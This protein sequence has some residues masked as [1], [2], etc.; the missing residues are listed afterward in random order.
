MGFIAES[1]ALA[2][3]VATR[4]IGSEAESVESKIC[5][6]SR[7]LAPD[8]AVVCECIG[9]LYYSKSTIVNVESMSKVSL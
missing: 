6:C 7:Y 8:A 3:L 5:T 1:A 2:L 9:S 4:R